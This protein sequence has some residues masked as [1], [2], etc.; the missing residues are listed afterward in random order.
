ML[1]AAQEVGVRVAGEAFGD[2]AYNEDGSLVAR[3]IAGSLITDPDRVAARVIGLAKGTVTAITGTEIRLH[4]DTICLHGD[5][6]GAGMI[7]KAVREALDAA[8][9]RVRPLGEFLGRA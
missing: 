3:K 7:A 8:G 9:V 4:A 6:P 5:T 1:R 2:R